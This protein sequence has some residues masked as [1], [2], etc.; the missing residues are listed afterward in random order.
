M[1][2]ARLCLYSTIFILNVSILSSSVRPFRISIPQSILDEIQ[3][4]LSYS[5]FPEPY[6][7]FP[8]GENEWTRGTSIR[9]LKELREF[10]YNGTSSGNSD[11]VAKSTYDWRVTEAAL[12]EEM[13]QF[14]TKIDDFDVHFI[15]ARSPHPHAIPLLFTH[16]WPGSFLECRK[17]LPLLTR[18][19]NTSDQAF[20]LIC[21][22]IPGYG[23]SSKPKKAGFGAKQ[24]A[25][26]F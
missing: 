26:L 2:D 21:P 3:T 16:G 18:P 23:F 1:L 12:N 25:E 4:K 15:H 14:I 13:P 7:S 10:W 19:T 9:Y 6:E 22:S 24:A 17:I 20:H 11:S 5:N 8:E